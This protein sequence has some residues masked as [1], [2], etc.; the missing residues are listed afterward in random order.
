MSPTDIRSEVLAVLTSIA[1]EVEPT[2]IIDD[3]PLRNQVDLD[4]MDWLNF[5]VG[6]AKRLGVSVAEKDYATLVTLADVVRYIESHAADRAADRV[7]G[8]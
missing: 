5:L 1:P 2:D 6:L 7:A 3:V 4:S 8:S